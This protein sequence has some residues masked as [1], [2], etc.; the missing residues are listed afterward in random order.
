MRVLITGATGFVGRHL[1]RLALSKK[2]VQVYGLVRP[3]SVSKL[4]MG[5]E[6]AQGDLSS[7]EALETILK[8]V[9]PGLIF[10]LAG[11]ASPKLAREDPKQTFE[12]NVEGTRRF[13]DAVV[14]SAPSARVLVA[15]SSDAYG[16]S[17]KQGKKLTEED[18]LQPDPGNVY[19][20]SKAKQECVALDFHRKNR[21]DI[22]CVRAFNHLGPGQ[23][24]GYVTT[25]FASKIDAIEKGLQEKAEMVTG[26]LDSV[27]DFTDVRDMAQAYWLALEKG[28]S[29]EV[30]NVASGVGHRMDEILQF[31]LKRVSVTITVCPDPDA[32]PSYF[33][34]DARKFIRTTGWQV[35]IPFETSLR[36]VWEDWREKC[37]S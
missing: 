30:Y 12:V 20:I 36:D 28:K 3:G 8:Q 34:G 35:S 17:A 4:V 1:S 6:P 15:G 24:I 7:A 14:S 10:H 2:N 23:D 32:R 13:L 37:A 11:Q 19:G 31:F 21:L 18:A 26:N 9:K 16:Q 33:I 5:V 27:R 25:D 29:G 22:V